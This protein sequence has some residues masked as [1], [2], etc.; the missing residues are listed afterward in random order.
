M[1]DRERFL[2]VMEYRPVDRVPNHEL[3]VWPQTVER[4]AAEGMPESTLHFDWF[5]GEVYFGMDRREFIDVNFGMMPEF[6]AGVIERTDR[7]EIIQHGNGVVT[8]ALINGTIGGGRSCM[9]QYL[10]FPV[11][12]LDDFRS[13]KKRY[14][15]AIPARYL[16]GWEEKVAGWRERKHVLVLGRNC[17][18]GGFYWRARQWMGTENLSYAWHDQPDLMHEMMEFYADFTIE[19]AR[20]IVEQIDVDYFNLSEDFAMKTGPLLSPDTFKEFIYSPMKRVV[21]FFKSHGAK[22]ICLDSDGRPEVLIPHLMDLGIDLIWPLERA[23]DMDPVR[24]R[25]KFGKSLRLSGGV[26]KRELAK[27]PEA[28]EAHLRELVPLIEEGGFIPTIDHTVPPDV[29]WSDFCYYMEA[30]TRLLEG[31]L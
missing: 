12:N 4:W 15:A 13:L 28:I 21:E 17:A 20:P 7:Y 22:Y 16:V 10:R 30:K 1:N 8:K 9:D 3:G 31:R 27:G 2:A 19:T 5:V 6:E 14:E 26:D 11:E 29:S 25:R 24:L 23:S 18:A